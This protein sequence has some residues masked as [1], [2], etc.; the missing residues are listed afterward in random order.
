MAQ[1]NAFLGEVVLPMDV[2]NRRRE[3]QVEITFLLDADGIMQ[4]SA[5]EKATSRRKDIRIEART[6]MDAADTARSAERIGR[7]QIADD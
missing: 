1:D 6:A 2:P 3:S 7:E 4:V 5:L